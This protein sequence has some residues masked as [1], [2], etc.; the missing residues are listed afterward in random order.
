MKARKELAAWR[1][2]REIPSLERG[3]STMHARNEATKDDD[4]IHCFPQFSW[5]EKLVVPLIART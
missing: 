2:A 4:D 1:G 5:E 3:N